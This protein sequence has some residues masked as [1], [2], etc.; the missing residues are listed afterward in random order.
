MVVGARH[1]SHT[2]GGFLL[3][4][5]LIAGILLGVA[6]AVVIGLAS[7]SILAQ[8]GGQDMATAAMLADEQLNLVL[9]RGPDNYASRYAV[10]GE[11]EE[12]FARFRYRVE[13]AGSGSGGDA[14]RVSAIVVWHTPGGERQV[15]LRTLVAPRQTGVEGGDPDPERIP[16]TTVERPL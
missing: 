3:V 1:Y 5:V 16:E 13:I 9:A 11:C 8:R 10:E 14:Y 12:P 15:A 6:L 7:R 2:R 4:D